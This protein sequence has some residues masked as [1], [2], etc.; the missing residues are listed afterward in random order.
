MSYVYEKEIYHYF[1]GTYKS[2]EVG[3][4]NCKPNE[5]CKAI[6]ENPHSRNGI[7]VCQPGV[8]YDVAT[9]LCRAQTT[10]SPGMLTY[11]QIR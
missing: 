7:C 1:K 11:M 3:V 4:G 2:C 6:S 8:E 10:I 9:G 5:M